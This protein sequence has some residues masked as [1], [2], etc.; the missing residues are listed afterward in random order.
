M[1]WVL[2]KS[3]RSTVTLAIPLGFDVSDRQ[4]FLEQMRSVAARVWTHCLCR[5]P[6]SLSNT[7][8]GLR[9]P[10]LNFWKG[11]S[12]I[13]YHLILQVHLQLQL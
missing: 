5:E 7:S 9:F 4:S 11:H 2:Q 6:I 8:H 1:L 3:R 10:T 12:A 13:G